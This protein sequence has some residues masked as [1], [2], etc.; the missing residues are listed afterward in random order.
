MNLKK[1][2]KIIFSITLFVA[3]LCFVDF[4]NLYQS[5]KLIP[6]Y[7]IL[8]IIV[9]YGLGQVISA[10]KW[11]FILRET[12]IDVSF[13]KVLVSYYTGMFVNSFALGILGGD[14][15]RALLVSNKTNK[16]EAMASVFADRLQGLAV[17]AL[18][19][20]FCALIFDNSINQNFLILLAVIEVV[21]IFVWFF[22]SDIVLKLLPHN[23]KFYPKI[24]SASKSFPRAPKVLLLITF[25]SVAFHLLQVFLHYVMGVGIGVDISFVLLL[26]TIPFVNIL[27]SLPFSWQGLGV[28][29]AGY[30]YFLSAVLTKEEI[31]IFGAIWLLAVTINSLLGGVIAFLS[32]SMNLLKDK[33]SVNS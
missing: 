26:A 25:I 2:I 4:N 17:L 21:A 30:I 15:A 13:K 31:V 14:L 8:V 20:T 19:G 27:T 11:Y 18:L 23:N 7:Y 29:E 12:H 28:R 9:G 22:G 33:E 24:E 6:W 1:I 3:V 10:A 16:T 5:F 32:G